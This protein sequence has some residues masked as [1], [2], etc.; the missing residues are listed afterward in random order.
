MAQVY[1][2]WILKRYLR[3]AVGQGSEFWDRVWARVPLEPQALA[4]QIDVRLVRRIEKYLPKGSTLLEGGCGAGHYVAWFHKKGFR[5]IGVD[6]A[7]ETVRRLREVAPELDVRVGDIRKLPFENESFDGYY[8]GGVIEHFE[9][10]LRPQIAEAFRVLKHGGYFFVTVPYVNL[11]RRIAS[12]LFGDRLKI[13]LDGRETL[14]LVKRSGVIDTEPVPRTGFHFH[15]YVLS[16]SVV[17]EALLRQGFVIV[18]EMPFSARWGLLDIQPYR[19]LAG[20]DLKRRG[21]RHRLAAAPLRAIDW[22]E[23]QEGRLW[24][25]LASAAGTL[26]GNLRL[27][28]A[29]RP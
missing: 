15:E 7:E 29:R 28:V 14:I 17:R 13:D 18:D 10:G 6:F 9:D 23:R 5:V 26:L 27:Y 1:P 24:G 3:D 25:N 19:R 11:T 2:G 20:I 12:R 16:R 22:I 4:R 8:S 21:L